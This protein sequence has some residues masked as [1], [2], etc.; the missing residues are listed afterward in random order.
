MFNSF[1]QQVNVVFTKFDIHTLIDIII[2]DPTLANFFL[3]SCTTKGFVT[4]N[5]AQTEKR[6]YHN[7]HL[8]NQFL[9]LIIEV[10][11]GYTNKLMCFYKIVLMPFGA[12]KG[13]TGSFFLSWL[14]FFVKKFSIMLQRMQA[15][16]IIS[17]AIV[18]GLVISHLP[19]L[20][21]TPPIAMTNLL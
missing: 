11:G 1:C 13:Q 4:S 20:H 15:S 14:F 3:W 10:F 21:D 7:Q 18:V 2:I 6:N 16:T 8:T 19:P 12:P 17:W 9:P 5:V